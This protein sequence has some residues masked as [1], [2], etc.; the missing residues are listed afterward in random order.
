MRSINFRGYKGKLNFAS[1]RHLL[2]TVSPYWICVMSYTHALSV[3]NIAT[4]SLTV[5]LYSICVLP[6][7]YAI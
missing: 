2:L 1:T 5:A 3:S 6:Y 7:T 4:S